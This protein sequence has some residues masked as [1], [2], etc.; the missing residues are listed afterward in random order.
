MMPP[1]Q[2][3]TDSHKHFLK[4]M[5]NALNSVPWTKHHVNMRWA[6]PQ[7]IQIMQKMSFL[8]GREM[9]EF[10]VKEMATAMNVDMHRSRRHESIVI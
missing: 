6:F 1:L 3:S 2:F 9:L 5:T 4:E 8:A 7:H 10:I